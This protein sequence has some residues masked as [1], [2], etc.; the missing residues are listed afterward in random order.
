MLVMVF[1]VLIVFT[2]SRVL[3]VVISCRSSV[4]NR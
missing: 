3:R 1:I 2:V 4:T